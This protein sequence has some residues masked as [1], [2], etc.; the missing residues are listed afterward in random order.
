MTSTE[1]TKTIVKILDN[2]KATD[3]VAAEIKGIST[4]GDYFIIAS[5][6]SN[7][8]VKALTD[9]LDERLSKDHGIEPKRIEGYQS[10]AWVLMDYYDVIVHIFHPETRE[11]YSLERLWADAPKLDI[12]QLIK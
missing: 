1:L 8:Q 9:E 5:G 6:T 4:L 3:I 2:K 11:F 7:N 12:E 10:A